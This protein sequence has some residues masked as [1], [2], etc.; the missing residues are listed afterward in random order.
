MKKVLV[1]I[2]YNPVSEKV[3]RAALD[4]IKNMPAE[5]CLI[6]VLADVSYYGAEFPTFMGYDGYA[7]AGPDFEMALE[8]RKVAEDF[9][10][11]AAAHI[12]HPNVSTYLAEGGTANAILAYAEEWKADLLVMGTHSHSGLEKLL[13]GTVAEKVIEKTKI[14]VYLV[15]VKKN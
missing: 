8:M 14:P 7:G 5:I 13:M 4:L 6:H 1:A 12:D 2:D 11:K 3:A 15:P 9:L 10:E